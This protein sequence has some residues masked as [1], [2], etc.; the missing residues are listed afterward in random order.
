MGAAHDTKEG[1]STLVASPHAELA[2]P[3]AASSN[4]ASGGQ[5]LSLAD[6]A[7]QARVYAEHA[8][9]VARRLQYL[10]GEVELARDL[11]QETFVVAF[12]QASF[13]GD[14]SVRSW[15]Q[16]IAY[17]LW[18]AH[19]RKRR[20]RRA[21]DV[22]RSPRPQV[23]DTEQSAEQR[24][25]LE[26]LEAAM[27]TLSPRLREAFVLRHIEELSLQEA[28][29]LTGVRVSTLSARATKASALVRKAFANLER[30]PS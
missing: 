9:A 17:N 15:L 18:R 20:R 14:A 16:G 22:A 4:R 3:D 10:C 19:V 5:A 23:S 24:E 30:N 11:A 26:R 13:R 25:L 29:A 7:V 1:V 21:L 2:A 28:S 27:A 8:P 6:Q 12:S